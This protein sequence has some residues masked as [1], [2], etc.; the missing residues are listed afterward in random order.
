VN[1][2]KPKV[3]VAVVSTR[4][5]AAAEWTTCRQPRPAKRSKLLA[6]KPFDCNMN[7]HARAVAQSGQLVLE[8]FHAFSHRFLQSMAAVLTPSCIFAFDAMLLL[9]NFEQQEQVDPKES[10]Y[11]DSL[12][13]SF[14]LGVGAG[15]LVETGHM[16]SKLVQTPDVAGGLADCAVGQQEAA[17]PAVRKHGSQVFCNGVL[18]VLKV[19]TTCWQQQAAVF[20]LLVIS[21]IAAISTRTTPGS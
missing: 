18:L 9:Y 16:L 8:W 4:L 12:C 6:P 15:A 7:F 3:Q 20:H 19:G 14:L 1:A 2:H 10:P 13:R 21:W 17:G 11:F 5:N